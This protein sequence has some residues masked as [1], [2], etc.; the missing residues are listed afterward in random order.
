MRPCVNQVEYHVG[1]GDADQE[2]LCHCEK[3]EIAKF[4]EVGE[5]A[6][7]DGQEHTGGIV[8]NEQPI[9][10]TISSPWTQGLM[11]GVL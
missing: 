6:D 8:L 4:E 11:T 1:L 9:M 10:I 5:G 7:H 2:A 3:E